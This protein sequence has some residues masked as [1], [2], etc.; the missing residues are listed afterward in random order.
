MGPVPSRKVADELCVK[1]RRVEKRHLHESDT[2]VVGRL[3]VFRMTEHYRDGFGFAV[4]W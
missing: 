2:H 4:A 3:S 1:R